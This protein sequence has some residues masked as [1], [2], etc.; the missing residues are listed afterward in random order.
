MYI[1]RGVSLFCDFG[2][3]HLVLESGRDA[4]FG[5]DDG[6][7]L[8]DVLAEDFG[9]DEPGQPDGELVADE[10]LGWDLEDLCDDDDVSVCFLGRVWWSWVIGH[11]R[12]ISSRVSCFVSR[13]KQKIMNQAMR[14]RPA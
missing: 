1:C 5:G 9:F 13:T 2:E 11:L 4:V 6:G 3:K 8:R 14:F 12:S 10:F 7:R